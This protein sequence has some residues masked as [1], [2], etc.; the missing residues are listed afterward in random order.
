RMHKYYRVK[1]AWRGKQRRC[2]DVCTV[3]VAQT[4]YFGRFCF[5][6]MST[7]EVCH[8]VGCSGEVRHV[9]DAFA[10]AAE[11][12]RRTIFGDIAARRN[13]CRFRHQVAAEIHKLCLVCSSTVENEEQR[14]AAAPGGDPVSVA[15]L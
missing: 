3:R 7:Y 8:L 11:I 4:N 13:H 10:G 15:F 9:V 12:A 2:Q 14:T 1:Q 6:D 5:L